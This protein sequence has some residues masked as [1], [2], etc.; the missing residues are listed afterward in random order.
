MKTRKNGCI[1]LLAPLDWPKQNGDGLSLLRKVCLEPE[2]KR[3]GC[4]IG[5]KIPV[6]EFDKLAGNAE[7]RLVSGGQVSWEHRDSVKQMDIFI[8]HKSAESQVTRNTQFYV[9]D[10]SLK[11]DR[12]L[13]R[14][15]CIIGY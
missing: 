13:D 5:R 6:S 15:M 1:R 8:K 10:S 3:K 9:G 12:I 14:F 7:C 4:V 11:L 2:V